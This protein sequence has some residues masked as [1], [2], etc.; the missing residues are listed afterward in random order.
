MAKELSVA[1][2]YALKLKL[3]VQLEQLNKATESYAFNI[4]Q[5]QL[6]RNEYKNIKEAI[7]NIP[8]I[9]DPTHGQAIKTAIKAIARA[10]ESLTG[11]VLTKAAGGD[12]SVTMAAGDKEKTVR[13]L[14]TINTFLSAK[15]T[16]SFRIEEIA[17]DAVVAKYM[18]SKGMDVKALEAAVA[19]AVT[20]GKIK[21]SMGKYSY[22]DSPKPASK[23]ASKKTAK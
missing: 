12:A 9:D 22:V 5:D 13:P 1:E 16:N 15:P 19:T 18:R 21:D 23:K 10:A 3:E 2:Q 11:K 8:D 4:E 17:A 20:E 14:R 6:I 7:A